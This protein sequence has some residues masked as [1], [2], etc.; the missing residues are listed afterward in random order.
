MLDFD[1]ILVWN[2]EYKPYET[3]AAWFQREPHT[4][5]KR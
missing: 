3:M 4:F 2:S 1:A 5:E